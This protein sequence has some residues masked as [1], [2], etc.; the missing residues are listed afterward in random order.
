LE[1]FVLGEKS[2]NGSAQIIDIFKHVLHGYP[3][4]SKI[5]E[6]TKVFL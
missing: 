2:T 3:E 1:D 6:G 4:I 5:E